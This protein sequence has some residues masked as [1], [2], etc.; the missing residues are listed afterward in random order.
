VFIGTMLFDER[1]W[2]KCETGNRS[3]KVEPTSTVLLTASD[4]PMSTHICLQ[5]VRPSPVPP[6]FELVLL[7]AWVKAEKILSA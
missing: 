3:S 2:G 5:M 4:P 7:S 1:V 6:Y